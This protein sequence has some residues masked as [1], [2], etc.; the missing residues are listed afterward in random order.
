MIRIIS[1]NT[2]Y[3][4][5]GNDSPLSLN[6]VNPPEGH[7]QRENAVT[8]S[9]PAAIKWDLTSRRR[10]EPAMA[11]VMLALH[12]KKTSPLD[13]YRPLRNYIASHY[14]ER[15]AQNQEDDLEFV[16]KLRSDLENSQLS[17]SVPEV[18]R[19]LFQSYYRALCSI[20]S[21][22]PISPDRDHVNTVSFVWYD[23]FKEKKK[24]SLQN[25]QLEK[26]AVIFNLGAAHSQI[27]LAADRTNA[28][29]IKVACNSF[30]AA[31]GAF[32][33][34]RDN[35]LI[36]GAVGSYATVDLSPECSAMLERLMLAQAQ[37]CFFEKV[38]SDAKPPGLCSKVARQVNFVFTDKFISRF[39]ILLKD[40]VTHLSIIF[41]SAK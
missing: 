21:R 38:I 32:A 6:H 40:F 19:D 28:A 13:L 4:P 12:E 23:A 15:E 22:F 37:E 24:A 34:L 39:S 16:R 35:A 41:L 8:V 5:Y 10:E 33:Y 29:G 25:I 36:R 26:A 17:D 27:A 11:N 30:Q 1:F 3:P 14:S 31:A 2:S 20:E 18:R 7:R 9:H